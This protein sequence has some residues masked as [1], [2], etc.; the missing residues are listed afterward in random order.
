MKG[1]GG[2]LT[3]AASGVNFPFTGFTGFAA[4]LTPA[5]PAPP[6]LEL[7]KQSAPIF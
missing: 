6:P 2:G 1:T 3:K 4:L 5:A 7:I